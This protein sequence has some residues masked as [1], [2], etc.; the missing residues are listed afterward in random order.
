MAMVRIRSGLAKR[1]LVGGSEGASPYIWAGF[2]AMRVICRKFND[3]PGEGLPAH[4]RNAPAGFVPGSGG[5]LPD[6]RGPGNGTGAG[7]ADLRGAPGRRRQLRRASHGRLHDGARTR[8]ASSAASAR[9]L[10][11][12]GSPGAE[13]MPSTA[14]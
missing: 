10:P 6:A 2:D 9:P 7:R 3:A 11:T 14:I 1:M 12:R 5:G 13:S 8:R 4:E